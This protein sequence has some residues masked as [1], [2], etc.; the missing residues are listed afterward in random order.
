MVD[1]QLYTLLA[2]SMWF[3][4]GF[5]GQVV[6]A[7]VGSPIILS[8]GIPAI[9]TYYIISKLYS[10]AGRNFQ[11]M[12]S[13][14]KSPIVSLYSE[15]ITG[16]GLSTIRAFK[17][18]DIWRDKFYRLN[19]IQS[20]CAVLFMEGKLWGTVYGSIA[21]AIL[22]GSVVIF[23]W[24]YMNPAAL[25]VSIMSAFTFAHLGTQ[26]VQYVVEFQSRMTSFGRIRFYSSQIPQEKS[27]SDQNPINA[28][29]N[30][31]SKGRL[32]Y[33]NVSFRYRSGLPYVLK[34]VNFKFK[35]G[36]KIGVCGRTGAGKSSLLFPLFRLVEL[37]PKLQPTMIDVN[38]GLPIESDPNEE[39]NKGEILIDGKDI[40]KIDLSKV[41][42]SI[43]IIPQDPTLFTGT[44]RYN[45]DIRGKYQNDNGRLWEVLGMVE[46]RDV[47][48]S[49]PLGLDTQVAEGGSNFSAGQRQLICFGRAILNNC[50]IVVMDEATASVDVETD[51]KIQRT[52]R[53]QF[54]DQTV[55]VI[56]HRLNTIMNSDRIMVMDDGRVAEI[57]K[58]KKL[59]KNQNSV[60]N[61]LI[62][63]L[64]H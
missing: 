16:A 54:V 18:E 7:A 21:S 64:Q 8:V 36:E 27:R 50:R 60:F 15:T 24:Y 31:P 4:I 25:S 63:S 43:A 38:T 56:A 41:R 28:K 48:A 44:L 20:S 17:L 52:I 49:L 32:Q 12:E 11:R 45:L 23:G 57:G 40:S 29:K 42:R 62:R 13:I 10:R 51:A 46:M 58:P 55:F 30:W 9:I 2:Q 1:Q 34:D 53:E 19:D 26:I 37:D 14:S 3:I 61:K 6:V 47:V 59:L 35:G 22:M 5:V 33:K 39:P